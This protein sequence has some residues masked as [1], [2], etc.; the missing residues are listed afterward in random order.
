MN[1]LTRYIEVPD[2][3]ALPTH[4]AWWIPV[5]WGSVIVGVAFCIMIAVVFVSRHQFKENVKRMEIE[6]A[7]EEVSQKPDLK[8][9]GRIKKLEN[10]MNGTG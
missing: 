4:P 8:L 2:C 7:R 9:D 5:I 3:P 6:L 10:Y 1:P